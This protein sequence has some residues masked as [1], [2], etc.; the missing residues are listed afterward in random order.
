MLTGVPSYS[1]RAY[2]LCGLSDGLIQYNNIRNSPMSERCSACL[3]RCSLL[4]WRARAH[5][6]EHVPRSS[7]DRRG[8]RIAARHALLGALASFTLSRVESA[9]SP[10][11]RGA[12]SALTTDAKCDA[13]EGTFHAQPPSLHRRILARF[14]VR[15]SDSDAHAE[16]ALD[17]RASSPSRARS[18]PRD[19]RPS[20]QCSAHLTRCTRWLDAR[21]LGVRTRQMRGATPS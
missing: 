5:I 21:G 10:S 7:Q 3:A 15:F 14:V 2:R 8:C 16:R 19:R 1:T 9:L 18:T 17:G 4:A 6:H 20:D 12:R 11:A 13:L